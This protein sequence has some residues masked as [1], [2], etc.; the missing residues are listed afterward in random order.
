MNFT[1]KIDSI[2]DFFKINLKKIC[3]TENEIKTYEGIPREV[4]SICIENN[5]YF[6]R[7]KFCPSMLLKFNKETSKIDYMNSYSIKIGKKSYTRYI[8]WEDESNEYMNF[9]GKTVFVEDVNNIKYIDNKSIKG[10]NS[11]VKCGCCY[12]GYHNKDLCYHNFISYDSGLSSIT[13]DIHFAIGNCIVLWTSFFNWEMR[14]NGYFTLSEIE[15]IENVTI[16]K[17]EDCKVKFVK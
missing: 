10:F 5:L 2:N 14:I 12:E 4:Y 16:E 6:F 8:K 3:L 15:E 11:S 9:V 1:S 13:N 7:N 17:N